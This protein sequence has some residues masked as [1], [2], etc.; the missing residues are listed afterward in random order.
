MEHRTNRC[1]NILRSCPRYLFLSAASGMMLFPFYWM[2][3][4]ALK[5]PAEMSVY[6][7]AFFPEGL[8][9]GNFAM[10][11]KSPTLGIYFFNSI[12]VALVQTVLVVIITTLTAYGFYRYRFRAKKPLFYGLLLLNVL[13][14]EVVMIFNYRLMIQLG[15]NNTL[16]ALIIP[17]CCKFFYVLILYNAFQSIPKSIYIAACLDRASDIKFLFRIA[18]PIVRP[19]IVYICIMNIVSS[20]NAFI[21]PL[22]ITNSVESRTLP[23]GIYTYMTEIGSNNTL[24]MAMSVLSQLPMILMLVVL[25]KYFVNGYRSTRTAEMGW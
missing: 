10:V 22:M 16:I 12:L 14:F 11:L 4:T 1:L 21:W 5:T 13:P 19:T 20:W 3:I 2:L 9:L 24:I 7:P 15:L 6:P 17:F 23:F 8:Y 18:L 25:R